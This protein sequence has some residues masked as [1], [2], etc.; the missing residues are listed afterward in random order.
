MFCDRLRYR[1]LQFIFLF[2]QKVFPMATIKS[3]P[4][5]KQSIEKWNKIQNLMCYVLPRSIHI[6]QDAEKL[7]SVLDFFHTT[8]EIFCNDHCKICKNCKKPTISGL[9]CSAKEFNESCEPDDTPIDWETYWD[10]LDKLP[11]EK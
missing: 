6:G 2:Y 9:S 10:T 11:S 4:Y 7:E 3:N 1:T 8:L 5:T